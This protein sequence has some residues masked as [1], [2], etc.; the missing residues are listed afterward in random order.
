MLFACRSKNFLN[1]V[2]YEQDNYITPHRGD[3]NF[4]SPIF[5]NAAFADDSE[6]RLNAYKGNK[7]IPHEVNIATLNSVS[8]QSTSIAVFTPAALS[9]KS[10]SNMQ[11][12]VFNK[13][14]DWT[15]EDFE[16]FFRDSANEPE[17]EDAWNFLSQ[18]GN[19]HLQGAAISDEDAMEVLRSE[20]VKKLSTYSINGVA[21]PCEGLDFTNLSLYCSDGSVDLSNCT[22]LT[23]VQ[24]AQAR[25]LVGVIL[26]TLDLSD[27]DMTGKNLQG[28]DFSRCTG[29]TWEQ[30]ASATRIVDSILPAM[31]LSAADMSGKNLWG[32]DF[33]NC[34]GLTGTQLAS[35]STVWAIK[36]TS[37]QYATVKADIPS[38][39]TIYID[40]VRT[41]V[42]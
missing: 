33:T 8:S 14:M 26:P 23:W 19:D 17:F 18:T 4:G 11:D 3:G 7:L 38:G 35:A 20:L 42:P 40:G 6:N 41:I 28:V 13:F 34:T 24:L 16:A 5:S 37:E 15:R 25:E 12:A 36:L 29:L 31:D 2:S 32:I 21:F 10:Y 39:T 22:G 30:L 27:A 1:C 9:W